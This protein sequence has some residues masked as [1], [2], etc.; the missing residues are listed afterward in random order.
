MP[1]T[2]VNRGVQI[3]NASDLRKPLLDG[4]HAFRGYSDTE[5]LLENIATFGV[6]PTVIKLVGMF[7]F[8]VWDRQKKILTL[9]RDR[10]G[11]KPL[12]YTQQNGAFIFGSVLTAVSKH[13]KFSRDIDQNSIASFMR[14]NYIPG[15]HSIYQG[16]MKL[17]PGTLLT[18]KE[19]GTREQQTY[20][21]VHQ[22]YLDGKARPF[23]GSDDQAIEELESL[24]T[25]AVQKRLIADVPLGAFLS[26]GIDSS[27]VVAL[28]QKVHSEPVKTF[29]IGFHETAYN[30]APYAKNVAAALGTDHT[31]LY[32][33][34]KEIQA[35][36]PGLPEVFD[37]PFADPSQLPTML[38]SRMAK[39]HVTVCLSGDGGVEL[40]AGYG[41]YFLVSKF[42]RMR[43]KLPQLSLRGSAAAVK[44]V[45]SGVWES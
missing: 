34:S 19:D 42:N 37:E 39:E 25:D 15:P 41:R 33:D 44:S 9:A 10:M 40:F 16:V 8:A 32:V 11:V 5:V 12:Y 6:W 22:A 4:G 29:S 27:L 20:W 3:Y 31:E 43:R 23:E 1:N 2:R 18:I 28:M 14:R 38:V 30:E 24:L 13:P 7:A 26:G 45:P 36:I 35:L 17:K 21:S